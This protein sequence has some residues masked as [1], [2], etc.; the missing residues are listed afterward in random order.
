MGQA[1]MSG[2]VTNSSG[3]GI[4]DATVSV[5]DAGTGTT[6]GSAVTNSTGDY[7]LTVPDGT[8]TVRV[9]GGGFGETT[10]LNVSIVGL[11]T[12]NFILISG[13]V[14]LTGRLLGPTGDPIANASVSL[15][16]TTTQSTTTAADGSFSFATPTGSYT[17][18][19]SA[20]GR[21]PPLPTQF[22]FYV[23][24]FVLNADRVQDFAV[25]ARTATFTVAD[26]SNT[27]VAGVALSVSCQ[28]TA[29]FSMGTGLTATGYMCSSGRSTNAQGIVTTGIVPMQN[30]ISFRF[31]PPLV[32]GLGTKS[33]SIRPLSNDTA[34]A[35][36]LEAAQYSKLQDATGNGYAT[37]TV[38]A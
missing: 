27:P 22:Y 30:E 12:Q 31:T 20:S 4:Q 25:P 29:Q 24:N 26:A 18:T 21:Q 17:I 38:T 23:Q 35:I 1:T 6:V 37:H 14:G 32:S 16:S 36:T 34:L 8:Y 3:T 19:F 11:K 13:N 28:Y 9:T 7:S 5:I 10:L 2:R 15:S 33:V